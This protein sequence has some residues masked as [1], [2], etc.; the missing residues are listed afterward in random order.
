MADPQDH[1]IP[2]SWQL[3]Q[4]RKKSLQNGANTSLAQNTLERFIFFFFKGEKKEDMTHLTDDR[5]YS[6]NAL[7]FSC[8]VCTIM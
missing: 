7:M 8:Y 1:H 3:L 6:N 2:R 5:Q 4:L